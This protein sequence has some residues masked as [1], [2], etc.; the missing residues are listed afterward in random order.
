MSPSS[1]VGRSTSVRE[2]VRHLFRR[3]TTGTITE[4]QP[5]INPPE[6]IGEDSMRFAGGP[7][8]NSDALPSFLTPKEDRLI[9]AVQ[10]GKTDE[11]NELLSQHH[12]EGDLSPNI[13]GENGRTLLQEAVLR[14]HYSISEALIKHRDID[15]DLSDAN[16][17][18][19][20]LIAAERGR[21]NE[22]RLLLE[23]GAD[24]TKGI[25]GGINA[26]ILSVVNGHREVFNVLQEHGVDLNVRY[27]KG[28]NLL[29]AAAL[30]RRGDIVKDLLKKKIDPNL[31]HDNGGH[32]ALFYAAEKGHDGIA[33]D[34]LEHGAKTDIKTRHGN[35]PL[36]SASGYQYGVRVVKL[37]LKYDADPNDRM[38]GGHTALMV[39]SKGGF[40]DIT[41]VLLE[42]AAGT[43]GKANPD[44]KTNVENETP[45]ILAVQA[46][47]GN[48]SEVVDLLLRNNAD[49]NLNRLLKKARET[50]QRP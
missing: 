38:V 29:M 49:P 27:D 25:R 3:R 26:V 46:P 1:E 41:K 4:A 24:S 37:L 44:A 35:T 12:V 9:K 6:G 28:T 19:P 17:Y 23:H 48:P 14:G 50:S 40:S 18:T 21:P 20:L 32:T 16:A 36:I 2:T 33:R 34:L 43:K 8:N 30:Y 45:L 47:S 7:S 13:R 39:A 15:I 31:K 22:T 42:N 5:P 10:A 11:V